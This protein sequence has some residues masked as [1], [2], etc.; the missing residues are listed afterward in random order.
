MNRKGFEMT[1][2][3][4]IIMILSIALLAILLFMLVYQAGFFSKS[5]KSQNG[6]STVDSFVSNC[7]S[8]LETESSYSYCCDKEEVKFVSENKTET[9]EISCGE[10]REYNWSKEKLEVFDC[11]TTVC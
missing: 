3:T 10:A 9:V 6:E 5:L 1:I 11:L 4:I 7:N 8:L 2:T